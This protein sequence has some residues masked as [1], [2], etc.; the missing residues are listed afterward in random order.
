[1]K[2]I[3]TLYLNNCVPFYAIPRFSEFF[4]PNG[5]IQLGLSKTFFTGSEY[6]ITGKE[7]EICDY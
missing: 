2:T 5:K 3:T 7:S 6:P 4:S 1:M